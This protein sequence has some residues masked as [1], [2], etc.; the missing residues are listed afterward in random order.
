MWEAERHA[1]W[2]A[3][4]EALGRSVGERYQRDVIAA[5][6]LE[7]VRQ[8]ISGAAESAIVLIA[9]R[10]AVPMTTRPDAANEQ[11]EPLGGLVLARMVEYFAGH[12]ARMFVRELREEGAS[13]DAIAEVAALA[14][15]GE[16]F[17]VASSE[18]WMDPQ[19]GR[20]HEDGSF[21]W[22]CPHC[23]K[24]VADYGPMAGVELGHAP[25]CPRAA[26][27]TVPATRV[28]VAHAAEVEAGLRT[29]AEVVAARREGTGWTEI[30]A[31]LGIAPDVEGGR[32]RTAYRQ[33]GKQLQWNCPECGQAIT[34]HGPDNGGARGHVGGCRFASR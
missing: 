33:I 18:P 23:G 5:M 21:G 15:P 20:W 13:W 34:D 27:G 28:R 9:Q 16:A 1:A 10:L 22:R 31:A 32:A 8:H 19:S 12:R 6:R 7:A 26:A 3:A 11:P 30:G 29:R 2:Q 14:H 4:A 17:A 24:M 25:D